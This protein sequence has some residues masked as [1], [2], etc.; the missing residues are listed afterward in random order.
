V[1]HHHESPL[2]AAQG[3]DAAGD[4][5]KSIDIEPRIG[6]IQQAKPRLEDGHLQ[7]FVSLLLPAGEPFMTARASMTSGMST[8]LAFSLMSFSTSIA[9]NSGKPLCLRTD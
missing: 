2:R 9:S 8:S 7:D 5:L 3:V 4:D 6:L 1:R